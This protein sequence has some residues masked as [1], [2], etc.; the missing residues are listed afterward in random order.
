MKY[1]Y[2]ADK[3]KYVVPPPCL[4]NMMEDLLDEVELQHTDHL[5]KVNWENVTEWT[6]SLMDFE[7]IDF[8]RI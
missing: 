3:S 8:A 7:G 5:Q 2:I 4:D 1:E 6:E